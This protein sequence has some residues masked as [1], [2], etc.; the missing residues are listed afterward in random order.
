MSLASAAQ[1]AAA[2]D[3]CKG[4]TIRI[5]VGFSAGADAKKSR[6][7]VDPIPAEEIE[8]DISGLFKLD[9]AW[10]PSSKMFFTTNPTA[11]I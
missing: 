4:K 2:D 7:N 9:P 6:L 8:K 3:F 11:D 10:S 1:G 5:V